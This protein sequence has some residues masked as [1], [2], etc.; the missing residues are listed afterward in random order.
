M[1]HSQLLVVQNKGLAHLFSCLMTLTTDASWRCGTRLLLHLAFFSN[2]CFS[3]RTWGV[4]SLGANFNLLLPSFLLQYHL[5][6]S[7]W[8][9]YLLG[10]CYT[11]FTL[12]YSVIRTYVA[13]TLLRTY[14]CHFVLQRL[15]QTTDQCLGGQRKATQAGSLLRVW[16]PASLRKPINSNLRG[17]FYVVL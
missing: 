11:S 5:R 14:Q 8:G 6:P 12:A 7:E 3:P 1:P 4:D 13:L 10:D 9:P 16:L 15:T 2:L 17:K